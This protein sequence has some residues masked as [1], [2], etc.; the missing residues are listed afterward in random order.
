MSHLPVVVIFA[1]HETKL[2]SPGPDRS[3]ETR[4]LDCRCYPSDENLAEIL[5]RDRPDVLAVFGPREQFPHLAAAPY[6][7][8]KKA[9]YFPVDQDLEKAGAAVYERYLLNLFTREPKAPPLV[10][11]FTPAYRTGER[12]QRPLRSLQ[13]QTYTN[14]QWV[15]VDDSGD[16]GA[17]LS[18]LNEIAATDARIE[19]HASRHSGNIGELKRRACLIA[20]GEILVELDHDD[21]L[22]PDAL[23]LVVRAFAQ[24]PE[25]GFVYTDWA[26]KYE[27]GGCVE[28][29]EGWAFGFGKYEKQQ[30]N[31]EE[32]L[33]AQAPNINAKTI[34]HII[35]VPNH[36]RAWRRDAYLAM[37]GH[38]ASLH[39]ADDY[40]LL[41]R[42]FLHTRMVRVP[43]LCYIQYMNTIGN[44]HDVRRAEIQR[45]VRY[46]AA[47]YD[48]RIHKRLLQLGV[49]DWVWEKATGR[50][51]VGLDWIP[52]QK[53]ESHCTLPAKL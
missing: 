17:T 9:L 11:V 12:I 53:V 18:M 43:K 7:I 35:G 50:C 23:E 26:E 4:E 36:L 52:N 1:P 40:E 45:L 49:D 3:W 8:A 13:N 42:T 31:G 33:V 21:E 22:T 2:Q 16:D 37:G 5:V 14:W 27:T 15:L 24:Y 32:L 47:H 6:E 20:Q 44:T 28:Y 41:V 38:N 51:A 19:V 29:P 46:I 30:Y 48:K 10:S 25:A 39:V 34:R